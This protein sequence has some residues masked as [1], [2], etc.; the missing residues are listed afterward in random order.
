MRN[1][2]GEGKLLL[3]EFSPTAYE[4]QSTK[5]KNW[6]TILNCPPTSLSLNTLQVVGENSN[7]NNNFEISKKNRKSPLGD[8]C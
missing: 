4:N 6:G 7:N 8:G 2:E 1:K 5:Y 3:L